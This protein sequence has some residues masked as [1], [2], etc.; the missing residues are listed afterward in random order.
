MVS[1]FSLCQLIQWLQEQYAQIQQAELFGDSLGL[2][3]HFASQRP[4]CNIYHH[5][6]ID[7]GLLQLLHRIPRKWDGPKQYTDA[8]T[9]SL[10]MLPT[11]MALIWDKRF[12]PYVELYAKD[13][14]KFYQVGVLCQPSYLWLRYI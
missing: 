8:A 7:F 14:D 5:D 4:A 13:Q 9:K 6:D 12:R 3:L 2:P 10:M 1:A 11:D